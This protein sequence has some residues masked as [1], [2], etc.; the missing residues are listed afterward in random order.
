[1]A[2]HARIAG[3]L[4]ATLCAA[5]PA[6]HVGHGDAGPAQIHREAAPAS[7]LAPAPVSDP[8]SFVRTRDS[9]PLFIG[10]ARSSNGEPARPVAA[11]AGSFILGAA[12]A[13]AARRQD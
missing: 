7:F 11:V 3:A 4:V 10:R 9:G 6:L 13:E 5:L 2:R 12:G 8:Q 1:M